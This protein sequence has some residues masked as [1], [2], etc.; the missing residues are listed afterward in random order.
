MGLENFLNNIKEKGTNFA[1]QTIITGLIGLGMM[2]YTNSAQSQSNDRD[3]GPCY[4]VPDYPVMMEGELKWLPQSVVG[5]SE[6]KSPLTIR[7]SETYALTRDIE[8][9]MPS[10]ISLRDHIRGPYELCAILEDAEYTG[11]IET[12][13]ITPNM[14]YTPEFG[15]ITLQAGQNPRDID[16]QAHDFDQN[17]WITLDLY[18]VDQGEACT[19]SNAREGLKFGINLHRTFGGE[20]EVEIDVSRSYKGG[21]G[22]LIS[23]EDDHENGSSQLESDN[24]NPNGISFTGGMTD[25]GAP[26]F[27][28]SYS[29]DFNDHVGFFV[30]GGY[31]GGNEAVINSDTEHFAVNDPSIATGERST[32]DTYSLDNALNL[33]AGLETGGKAAKIG[34]GG[35]VSFNNGTK[36]TEEITD[37]YDYNGQITGPTSNQIID[38]ESFE[39]SY[40]LQGK[41]DV[42]LNDNWSVSATGEKMF[43]D[44]PSESNYTGTIGFQR[45]F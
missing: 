10:G 37:F 32:R 16:L 13:K 45:R 33:T 34:L 38:T 28:G 29:R 40:G 11:Q 1:K 14:T 23:G 30:G 7:S 22:A 5:D 24:Y 12:T 31:E 41:L 35:V 44:N 36:T 8:S 43:D 2:G 3:C 17:H 9:N 4:R 15:K 39:P 20:S 6:D 27:N 21:E 19:V 18:R 42:R 26:A 25:T